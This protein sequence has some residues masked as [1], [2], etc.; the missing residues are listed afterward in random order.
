MNKKTLGLGLFL[1]LSC[2]LLAQVPNPSSGSVER[3]S[4]FPSQHVARRN[5]DVWLPEGYSTDNQYPVLYMHD[6]AML[7]DGANTWNGQE[8]GVD[9]VISNLINQGQIPPCIV[10]GVHNNGSWRFTE[11]FPEKPFENLPQRT[12]NTVLRADGGNLLLGWPRSDDYLKFLV[13]ELKPFI[14]QNYA[15]DPSQES[16]FIGG[17]S[18]GGLISW[19]A[20]CEYPA[21]F[22]GA[23]CLSTHWPGIMSPPNTAVPWGF[24]IY[25]GENLPS[26]NTHKIYFDHGT[27][28]LD[29]NYA[30]AQEQIDIVIQGAGY[31]DQNWM[32]YVAQGA[33]HDETS[34]NARLHIPLVFLMGDQ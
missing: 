15:T 16:T 7:F 19:Y 13:T 27:E 33:S 21:V 20:I 22:G 30:F 14:D 1:A 26:P 3:L 12:K 32:T 17:S 34:W 10:V 24:A 2:A 9:E 28:G 8:W 23:M 5:V 29:A 11:Y 25:L 18:M 6:G 31:S 4:L